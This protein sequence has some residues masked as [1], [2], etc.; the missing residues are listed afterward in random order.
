MNDDHTPVTVGHYLDGTPVTVAPLAQP[1]PHRHIFDTVP[2][3]T[4]LKTV[5]ASFT[6]DAD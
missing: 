4:S 3:R 6:R 1:T 2:T 5:E